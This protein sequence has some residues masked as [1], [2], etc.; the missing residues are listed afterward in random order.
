MEIEKLKSAIESIL[1]IAGEPVR[2]SRIAKTV[3]VPDD[4]IEKALA[5]LIAEYSAGRGLVIVRKDDFVQMATNPDNAHIIEDMVK[6]EIQENL[7]QASLEVL[8]I[9]A[10]RSPITRAEIEAIRGVN[11][12][13]TL[14]SLLMRGLIERIDNPKDN[15][16]YLYRISMDF[17]KKVGV[18]SVEKLPDWETL[19]HDSRVESILNESSAD[20][21]KNHA[22]ENAT[23]EAEK[24]LL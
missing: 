20:T 19:S 3:A 12:S 7:S 14:R 8:S 22:S 16:G 23:T 2:I 13:F 4:E 21:V 18:D 15:R 1:F 10:Y 11:C 6:S 17:L 5:S 9:I 24:V